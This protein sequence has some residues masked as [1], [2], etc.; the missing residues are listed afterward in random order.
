MAPNGCG[1]DY[2]GGPHCSSVPATCSIRRKMERYLVKCGIDP[3]PLRRKFQSLCDFDNY[4]DENYY[5][6][7]EF[8]NC[9]KECE[10]QWMDN[11]TRK[12]RKN[13]KTK[14]FTK[15]EIKA[16]REMKSKKM[17]VNSSYEFSLIHLWC[18]SDQECFDSEIMFVVKTQKGYTYHRRHYTWEDRI[19]PPTHRPKGRKFL[20]GVDA[21]YLYCGSCFDR[22]VERYNDGNPFQ[23]F[24][25]I[26]RTVDQKKEPEWLIDEA[27][28]WKRSLIDLLKD[29]VVCSD[30]TV[31]IQTYCAPLFDPS[32]I[33]MFLR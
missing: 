4:G 28:K 3:H 10:E 33:D 24:E 12:S 5:M 13:Y 25:D 17:A 20:K 26:K 9:M 23:P 11:D 29:L 15:D 2:C 16:L 6:E 32:Q 8:R 30:V 22:I 19:Q 21:D 14:G 27:K 7:R 31:L 1:C 18:T